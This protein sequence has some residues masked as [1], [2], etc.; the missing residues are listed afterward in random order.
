M[1][2]RNRR[3]RTGLR[4][5]RNDQPLS[6]RALE[7]P[8]V[9]DEALEALVRRACEMFEDETIERA[10]RVAAALAAHSHARDTALRAAFAGELRRIIK[11]H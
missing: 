2:T 6:G 5:C 4:R 1:A 3:S 10:L 8:V 7:E 9:T 11:A